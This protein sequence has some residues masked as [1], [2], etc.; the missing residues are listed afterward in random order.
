MLT[1]AEIRRYIKDGIPEDE[2][3]DDTL[4]R[5]AWAWRARGQR[6]EWAYQRWQTIVSQTT[7]TDKS[8]PFTREDFDRHWKRADA[9]WTEREARRRERDEDADEDAEDED[10]F[11]EA[12][13]DERERALLIDQKARGRLATRGWEEPSLLD[14]T[15][16]DIPYPD[17]VIAG[18]IEAGTVGHLDGAYGT[19]KTFLALDWACCVVTGMKWFGHQVHRG[20]V[21]YVA[22]EG[23]KGISRRIRAW[24][25]ARSKKI[26]KGAL[27]VVLK[28]VQ[29]ASDAAVGWLKKQ[30]RDHAA[31]F[32]IID[33]LARSIDG[34]NENDAGD[35]GLAVTALYQLRD[36]RG[37]A[38]TT[39]MAVVHAG[40]GDQTRSRGSSRLPSD[41]DWAHLMEKDKKISE[42]F[43]LTGKKMKEDQLPE[44]RH[45]TLAVYQVKPPDKDHGPVT[46]CALQKASIAETK[47]AEAAGEGEG[48]GTDAAV[49]KYLAEY[50]GSTGQ[51]VADGCRRADGTSQDRSNTY[52][53]LKRLRD[54]DHKVRSEGEGRDRTWYLA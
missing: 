31:D 46:S 8:W 12:E 49:L 21:L 41:A 27:S 5:C 37:E 35:M 33:T 34:L 32:V 16:L 52:K 29:L 13:V 36:A 40:W 6:E 50:P 14:S 44:S 9:E 53:Q 24:E 2:H 54:E 18:Y 51:E 7:L 43:H 4:S 10:D 22:A 25:L 3:H 11:F 38:L 39:V 45:F 19:A 48:K 30:I 1:H 17:W 20:N 26:E 42:L 47:A 15:E 28:P 23:Q